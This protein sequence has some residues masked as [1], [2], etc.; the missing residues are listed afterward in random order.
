ML[1]ILGA[2]VLTAC[3]N[4]VNHGA[5]STTVVGRVSLIRQGY[6]CLPSSAGMSGDDHVCFSQRVG[7]PGE[8]VAVSTHNGPDIQVQAG[9]VL[10]PVDHVSVRANC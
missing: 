7:S 10:W 1:L 3:Q 8:C 4:S 2:A 9:V 6:D 5:F